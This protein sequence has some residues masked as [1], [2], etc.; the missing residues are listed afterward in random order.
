MILLFKCTGAQ[1][2]ACFGKVPRKLNL[3]KNYL[4]C[5]DFTGIQEVYIRDFKGLEV[6]GIG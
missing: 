1:V 6:W 4:S 3:Q 2:E 5:A